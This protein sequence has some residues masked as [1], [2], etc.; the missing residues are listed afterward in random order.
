MCPLLPGF[1][2]ALE[3]EPELA[4]LPAAAI[5]RSTYVLPSPKTARH[6]SCFQAGAIPLGEA[7][8]CIISALE[9][10]V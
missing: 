7:G 6:G 2:A 3:L 5:R 10:L 1:W 9:E 8:A 4:P